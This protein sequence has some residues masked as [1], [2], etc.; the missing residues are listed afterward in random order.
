MARVLVLS[1]GTATCGTAATL[2]WSNTQQPGWSSKT[3]P[4]APICPIPNS[5][6]KRRSA[7]LG[8]QKPESIVKRRWAKF[9]AG[10]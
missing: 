7:T 4:S 5:E 2:R 8:V 9:A 3:E 10:V 6:P 1:I